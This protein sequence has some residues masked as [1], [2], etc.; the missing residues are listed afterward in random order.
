M[1]VGARVTVLG[2]IVLF[3]G[4]LLTMTQDSSNTQAGGLIM[5][6]PIPIAFG[7]SP[8][9]TTNILGIGLLLMIIYLFLWK[10][11]R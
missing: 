11:Q 1:K 3:L 4:I 2:F 8:E 7:S 9:I 10:M 5:L 6:G